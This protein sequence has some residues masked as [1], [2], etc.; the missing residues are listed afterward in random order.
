MRNR[1]NT[2]SRKHLTT[3][4]VARLCS[5]TPDTVYKWIRSGKIHAHR[6]P[7][8]HHRIAREEL[9]TVL[10]KNDIEISPAQDHTHFQYCWEFNSVSGILPRG[11][12]ECIVYRSGTKRCYEMS[13]LPREFGHLRLFCENSCD[14]CEYYHLVQGQRPNVLVVTDREVVGST[15]SKDE[16]NG[17]FNLQITDCEY[18]CSMQIDKFRPDYVVIDCSLGTTRSREFARLL[19]E[20]PRVPLVRIVLVG[21]RNELP[22]ECDKQVFA[23][24]E[25]E[26]DYETL[27]ELVTVG[28]SNIET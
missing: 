20:D 26:L 2:S 28:H 21:G 17:T 18:R 8:G 15:L 14:E 10:D 7:G 3:G 5:V 23:L 9:T 6:T 16:H 24:V 4:E 22:R 11:C 13:G 12:K 19:N 25:G 1:N 27:K